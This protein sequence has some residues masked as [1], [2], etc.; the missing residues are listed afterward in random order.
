MPSLIALLC[1][2]HPNRGT[3][4]PFITLVEGLWAY[5][6]AGYGHTDHTWRPIE[7]TTVEVLRVRTSLAHETHGLAHTS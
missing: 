4:G 2:K 6:A 7:P 5:C 1:E 3:D